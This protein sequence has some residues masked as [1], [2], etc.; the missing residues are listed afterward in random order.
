MRRSS[1]LNQIDSY[2]KEADN[3]FFQNHLFVP[4][5]EVLQKCLRSS[6][7]LAYY[8]GS[9]RFRG[10]IKKTKVICFVT[11]LWRY[12]KIPTAFYLGLQKKIFSLLLLTSSLIC[13]RL[14][15]SFNSTLLS[16][17]IMIRHNITRTESRS[18]GFEPTT[19][20]FGDPRSTELN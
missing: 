1:L 18:V 4:L 20:G 16:Y 8:T 14:N 10:K 17:F 12:S 2:L 9:D 3:K 19:S 11:T 5:L 7:E 15:S 6:Q 13:R